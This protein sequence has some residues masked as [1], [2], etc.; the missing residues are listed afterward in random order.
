MRLTLPHGRCKTSRTLQVRWEALH[1]SRRQKAAVLIVTGAGLWLNVPWTV[2]AQ[3]LLL[4]AL[5]I[6]CNLKP[7]EVSPV[8]QSKRICVIC[9]SVSHPLGAA[10]AHGWLPR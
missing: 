5:I 2:R 10:P 3:A 1:L 7:A 6:R 9:L 4:G 8:L